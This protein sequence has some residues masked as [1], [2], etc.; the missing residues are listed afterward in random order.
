MKTSIFTQSTARVSVPQ[1]MSALLMT[2]SKQTGKNIPLTPNKTSPCPLQRG[3]WRAFWAVVLFLVMAVTA[4]AQVCQIG[5]TNY[6][7]LDAALAAHTNGQTIRLL[8][9][10][11]HNTGI[12]ISGKTLYF[13]LNGKNLTVSTTG[14]GLSVS[15]NGRVDYFGSGN[16][17]VISSGS[18]AVT[19]SGSNSY[20][21]VLN[22][23]STAAGRAA[24]LA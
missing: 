23:T 19:V 17:D 1:M 16:F 6:T 24:V 20:A 9:N 21:Y 7:T 5:S 4:Q 13:D 15:S 2:G 3:N 22:A 11:N 18:D 14:T 12:A 8:A 10:I